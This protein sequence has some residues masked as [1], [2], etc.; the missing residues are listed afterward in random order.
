M[1]GTATQHVLL[2]CLAGGAVEQTYNL[3]VNAATSVKLAF[4]PSTTPDTK[5]LSVITAWSTSPCALCCL[6]QMKAE[7]SL[8][9]CHAR[10]T[11]QHTLAPM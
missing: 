9:R 5:K 8:T 2:M 11:Y 10:Q 4:E 1:L 6:R 7:Q 3:K